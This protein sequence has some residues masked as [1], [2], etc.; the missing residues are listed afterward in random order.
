MKRS[1]TLRDSNFKVFLLSKFSI[2]VHICLHFFDFFGKSTFFREST[3]QNA[4][5]AKIQW[6]IKTHKVIKT[7]LFMSQQYLKKSTV[8]VDRI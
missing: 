6:P 5:C 1:E 4:L 2:S 8:V 7:I 3:S